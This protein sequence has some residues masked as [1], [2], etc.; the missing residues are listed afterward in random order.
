MTEIF[1]VHVG[2]ICM[3][4][5]QSQLLRRRLE[6][7][8]LSNEKGNVRLDLEIAT[9]DSFQGKEKDFILLCTT[10]TP[11]HSRSG[12][13]SHLCDHRRLNVAFSRAKIHLVVLGDLG[14]L[15][16]GD[17]T[18]NEA[19]K[20]CGKGT[21]A[22]NLFRKSLQ[23]RMRVNQEEEDDY[24]EQIELALHMDPDLL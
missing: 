2:V 5:A 10:Y 21:T 19:L 7:L 23:E 9:V 17:A 1:I 22:D 12:L 24:D 16:S 15:M 11:G 13:S 6:N 8:N 20:R 4:R 14:Y 18:W 3:Y